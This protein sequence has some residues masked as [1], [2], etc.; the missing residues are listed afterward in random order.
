MSSDEEIDFEKAIDDAN[1]IILLGSAFKTGIFSALSGEKEFYELTG[2]LNADKR[3][4]SIILEA[5]GSLG[6][7]NK[8]NN[9]YEIADKARPFFLDHGE[10][11]VGDYL[12]H[13]LN[14][15]KAWLDLELIIKGEKK[16]HDAPSDI[17]SFMKA[18]SSRPDRSVKFVVDEC[19][20]RKKNA[21]TALDLGGGP[22]KY[23]RAFVD[24]GL[25]VVLYD[26][27]EII[28]YVSRVFGLEDVTNLTL[29]KGDFTENEFTGDFK[30]G[31]FDIVFMGNISH[32][33]SEEE[34]ITLIDRVSRI[35]KKGGLIAIEDF[36]RGRSPDAEMFAVNMLANTIAGNT[37]TEEQYLKWL[38][39]AG[40]SHVEV[41]DFAGSEKQL[42][43]A[44]L[45]N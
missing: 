5:L 10:D 7:V 11:Y 8:K 17:A 31:S 43:T 42:I 23:A 3:A 20:K 21:K 33:Y 25:R 27:P 22:G 15:F 14:K 40:F 28:D 44:V 26:M 30:A 19:I 18:M 37:Y 36:V 4:L 35:L 34:N 16:G 13:T 41:L 24:K 32:I 29:K 6:F 2:E 45:E 1:K 39:N 12:P 9:R 38:K